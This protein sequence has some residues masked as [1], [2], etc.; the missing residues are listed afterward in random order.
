MPFN[1]PFLFSNEEMAFKFLDGEQGSFIREKIINDVGVRNLVFLDI[2]FRQL[3]T[4][5]TPVHSASDMAG[6]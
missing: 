5:N 6:S 4:K 1:L 3:T 2:G